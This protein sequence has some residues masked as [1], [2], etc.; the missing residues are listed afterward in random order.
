MLEVIIER[1]IQ[2]DGR[3][4][5]MWSLWQDGK[6]AAMS[7]PLRSAEEAEAQALDICRRS[8]KREPD[9]ITRL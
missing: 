6:R 1:W 7:Q 3:T 9:R 2:R 5:F 4:D 8:L